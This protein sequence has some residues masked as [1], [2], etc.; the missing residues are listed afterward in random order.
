V[1]FFEPKRNF[2][3]AFFSGA[4]E[5][6]VWNMR[7][8]PFPIV[9]A[10][11]IWNVLWLMPLQAQ[12]SRGMITGNITDAEESILPGARV[13]LKPGG[14]SEVSNAQGEFTTVRV[15]LGAALNRS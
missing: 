4:C 6:E 1:P 5:L 3:L 8:S 7:Q 14:Q 11:F 2:W 9:L 13:E 10:V 15:P 12:E